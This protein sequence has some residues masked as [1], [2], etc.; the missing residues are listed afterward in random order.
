MNRRITED[1]RAE[2]HPFCRKTSRLPSGMFWINC[3]NGRYPFYRY[4]CCR[5]G[6]LFLILELKNL[7]FRSHLPASHGKITFYSWFKYFHW[8]CFLFRIFDA[9]T[10][11]LFLH[12]IWIKK[13]WIQR[14]KKQFWH[15]MRRDGFENKDF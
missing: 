2:R 13:V 9:K 7:Y 5:G 6:F 14:N 4:F 10:F 12:K 3:G 1:N 15:V 11:F 8:N